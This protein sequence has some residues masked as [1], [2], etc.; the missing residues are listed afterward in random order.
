MTKI[1][2]QQQIAKSLFQ[3]LIYEPTKNILKKL[4]NGA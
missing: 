2:A 3:E 1:K 4:N